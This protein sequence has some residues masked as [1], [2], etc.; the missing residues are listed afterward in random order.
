M[1]NP[2]DG[3][4]LLPESDGALIQRGDLLWHEDDA[5]WQEAEG[6][7]IGDNVDGYYGVARRDS[8]SK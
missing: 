1:R 3:Y 5:E 8:Q 2:P 6:A 4:S 7:E